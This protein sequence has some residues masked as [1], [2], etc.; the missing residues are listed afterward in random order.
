LPTVIFPL[1]RPSFRLMDLLCPRTAKGDIAL[2]K[3]AEG[4][5]TIVAQSTVV[6]VQKPEKDAE[7]GISLAKMKNGHIWVCQINE[8][9]LFAGSSLR[10]GQKVVS[11]NGQEC[12]L[13]LQEAIALVE[14]CEGTLKIVAV[15]YGKSNIETP[16]EKCDRLY[17]EE[18]RVTASAAKE[19]K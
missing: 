10:A 11:I 9:G 13:D 16:E 6:T 17:P 18:S 12:Q 7:V 4:K 14:E 3:A 15:D 1:V 19:S 8:D 2:V 5:I